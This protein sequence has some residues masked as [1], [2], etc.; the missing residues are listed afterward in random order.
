ML[1]RSANAT[2]WPRFVFLFWRVASG[3]FRQAT[4]HI[5]MLSNGVNLWS[6]PYGTAQRRGGD[7]IRKSISSK[8]QR[9]VPSL[10]RVACV[11]GG[12]AFVLRT[13]RSV[14]QCKKNWCRAEH[15]SPD[16]D[17]AGSST[18]QHLSWRTG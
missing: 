15:C 5:S 14:V 1:S 3:A 11:I 16:Q 4:K 8:R 17:A 7:K 18:S 13:C 10:L 12:H 6:H 2:T 9:L